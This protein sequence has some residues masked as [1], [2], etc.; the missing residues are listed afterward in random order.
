M[1]ALRV[2][3]LRDDANVALDQVTQKDLCGRL[4]VLL[5]ELHDQRVLQRLRTLGPG[6]LPEE[7]RIKLK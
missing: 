4:L 3:A 1:D 7:R 2:D 6:E 5:R